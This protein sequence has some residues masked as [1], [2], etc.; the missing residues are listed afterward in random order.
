MV[1]SDPVDPNGP[2]TLSAVGPAAHGT[3]S[4]NPDGSLSYI[5]NAG[6]VGVDQFSFTVT[7]THGASATGTINLYVVTIPQMTTTSLAGARVGQAYS[8]TL[9]A[10]GGTGI[11]RWAVGGGQLPPGLVLNQATGVISGVP[12]VNGTYSVL[13]DVFDESDGDSRNFT[14]IV[15]PITITSGFPNPIVNTLYENQLFA[16]GNTGPVSWSLDKQN[17]PLLSWLSLSPSGLLSGT[18]PNYGNTP[19]FIITAT[20]TA[21]NETNTRIVSLNVVGPLEIVPTTLREGVVLE[22]NQPALPIVGGAGNRTVTLTGGSLPP[23]VTLTSTGAFTGSPTNHGTFNFTV[24]V[25]DATTTISRNITWR[26]SAREQLANPGSSA[27]ITFGGPGG[28]RIAQTFT[29]AAAGKLTGVGSFNLACSLQGPATVEIQRQTITGVPDGTTIATGVSTGLFGAIGLTSPVD[30]TIDDKLAFILSSPTACTIS[31]APLND[32]N[33]QAGDAYADAG[34]GWSPLAVTDLRYDIPFRTLIQPAKPVVYFNRGRYDGARASLLTGATKVLVT[35]TD[36]T[37]DVYD[38]TT[39]VATLTGTMNVAPQRFGHISTLLDDGTVLLAGGRD[40]VSTSTRLTSAEIFNPT[41]GVYTPTGSLTTGRESAEAVK[42]PNGKVLIVGGYDGTQNLASAE[43]YDP[44]AHTF[45]AIGPMTSGR[46]WPVVVPLNNGKILIAA[47]YLGG[48]N[49][50][51]AELFD[52]IAGTFTATTGSMVLNGRGRAT[53]TLLNDGRVLI[54]GGQVGDV[55]AEAE[56]Y[57]PVTDSFSA[58]APMSIARFTHTATLLPDGSVLVAGGYETQN[59]NGYILPLA[60]ME[61]YIP[62]TNTWVRAGSMEVRRASHVAVRLANGKVLLVGGTSQNGWFIGNTGELYDVSAAPALTTTTLADGQVNVPYPATQLSAIGGAGGPYQIAFVSGKLPPGIQ[63]DQATATLSS[64]PTAAGSFTAGF[65]VT[66]SGGNVNVQ[67]LTIRVGSLLTITSPY[68]LTD[69]AVNHAYLLQLT[70]SAPSTWS[71]PLGSPTLPPGLSLS[72]GGLITGTPTT[73]GYYNFVAR[74]ID[75]SGQSAVKSLSINVMNPLVITT[76]SLPEAVL[77]DSYNRCVSTTNWV[78]TRTFSVTTGSL[79]AGISLQGN[80]GCFTGTVSGLGTTSFTIQVTDTASPPQVHSVGYTVR[81]SAPDMSFFAPTN[82]DP[83]PLGQTSQ[84]MIGRTFTVGASGQLTG[85]SLFSVTSCSGSSQMTVRLFTASPTTGEPLALLATGTG[86]AFDVVSFPAPVTVGQGEQYAITF[87]I[88]AGDCTVPTPTTVTWM[89]GDAW[90]KIG[91]GAWTRFVGFDVPFRTHIAPTLPFS[92]LGAWRGDVAGAATANGKVLVT[93]GNSGGNTNTADLYDPVANIVERAGNMVSA[94]SKHS[95]TTLAGGKVLVAGGFGANGN[96]MSTAEVYDPAGSS[97]NDPT[98]KGTFSGTSNNLSVPRT[99]HTAT[100]L[101]DGR[102]LIVGGVNNNGGVTG[103]E[104]YDPATNLFTF[105]I[106]MAASRW[107]HSATLLQ[108]GKVLIVGGNSN[109]PFPVPNG[110]VYD[111]VQNTLT[112]TSES[113]QALRSQHAAFLR[114]DGKVM[115]VGG[116]R[117]YPTLEP[118]TEIYDQN[119]NQLT[120]GPSMLFPRMYPVVANDSIFG[121]NSSDAFGQAGLSEV[122][123]YDSANDRFVFA[124]NLVVKRQAHGAVPIAGGKVA[125][126]GG[127]SASPIAGRSLEV[128]GPG[129]VLQPPT[130]STAQLNQSYGPFTFNIAGATPVQQS[131]FSGVVADGVTFTPN[132]SATDSLGFTLSNVPTAVGSFPFNVLLTDS[133]GQQRVQPFRVRVDPVTITTTQLLQGTAFT[134][135][136]QS[137]QTSSNHP[138]LTF[139]LVSNTGAEVSSGAGLPPGLTLSTSGFVSGIPSAS[140]FYTFNVRVRDSLGQSAI[141][142]VAIFIQ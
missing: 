28:R 127:Y 94:R 82:Q 109:G 138:P 142:V 137:I 90:E 39:N 79:P 141:A 74:A 115:V 61:R 84:R 117:F 135:Y 86:S 125:V 111:P 24:Q 41:T 15:G 97:Q 98:A 76:S 35:G 47:G 37:G 136:G 73:L 105:K 50:R 29:V 54:T 89:P 122:E 112:P 91:N 88:A 75:G 110:E 55:R 45:T 139:T 58:A 16:G 102:V 48:S 63:Y 64:T 19:Q 65:R 133:L 69:A 2:I 8:Q 56:I 12:S 9:A 78:G 107:A 113:I 60:T 124:G 10:S 21:N 17:S 5:S 52:P 114:A 96:P 123:R 20:D 126:F 108:N 14:I 3:I 40:S 85:A 34:S 44:V 38:Q 80:T 67:T 103:I 31:N 99:Q 129:P 81:T 131:F 92:S 11:Y 106:N 68:R 118:V 104:I 46:N 128:F 119:T 27:N 51:S 1:V 30:V 70:A 116:T 36:N 42:L 33:Y 43:L 62:G 95:A 57:D 53:G 59:V 132:G 77:W 23:G 93:G 130:A 18:P 100:L 7:D 134:S 32:S 72:A 26:V 22:T 120:P 49:T 25:Q 140:G 71:I 87:Q 121:G 13:I 101:G 66:D 4:L 6:F 83:R